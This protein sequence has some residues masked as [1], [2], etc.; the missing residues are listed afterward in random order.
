MDTSFLYHVYGLNGLKCSKSEYK[1]ND[2]ILHVEYSAQ[3]NRCPKC[4]KYHTLVKKR[5][6][7]S[8]NFSLADWFKTHNIEHEGAA[9]QM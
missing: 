3:K 6:S 2:L 8:Q 1:G 7:S 5:I 4:G 9:L